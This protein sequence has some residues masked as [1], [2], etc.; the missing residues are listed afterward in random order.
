MKKFFCRKLWLIFALSVLVAPIFAEDALQAELS[1]RNVQLTGYWGARV[2]KEL[3]I[4]GRVEYVLR[5]QVPL[6]FASLNFLF[7]NLPQTAKLVNAY[8]GTDYKIKYLDADKRR[9][10]AT[11]KGLQGRMNLLSPL[12]QTDR[13]V[14]YG[15]GEGYFLWWHLYGTALVMVDIAASR[16][17]TCDYELRIF[18][19][20][21]SSFVN[22]LLSLGVVRWAIKGRIKAILEHIVQAAL[23]FRQDEGKILRENSALNTPKE[24]KFLQEFLR[25]DSLEA[26]S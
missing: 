10:L 20:N 4:D 6:G 13:R 25:L 5:G 22:G 8:R 21:E 12:A 26:G 15:D 3:Q 2:K 24:Q 14:Y 19:F 9:F 1:A 16:Q 11:I 23:E 18:L 17:Q 7:E